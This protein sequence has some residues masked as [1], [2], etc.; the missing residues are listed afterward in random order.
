MQNRKKAP[1]VVGIVYILGF[2][3]GLVGI[4][5]ATLVFVYALLVM[6]GIAVQDAAPLVLLTLSSLPRLHQPAIW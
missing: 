2:V 5:G 1:T 6:F 3:V 4:S